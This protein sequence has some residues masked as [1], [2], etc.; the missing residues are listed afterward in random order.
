MNSEQK[1][2]DNQ[3]KWVI[4]GIATVAVLA[5][6]AGSF[7]LI[8]GEQH[9]YQV[10]QESFVQNLEKQNYTELGKLLSQKSIK[11]SGYKTMEIIEKYEA[12]FNGLG[13]NDIKATNIQ[14]KKADSKSTYNLTY[15]LSMVTPLGKLTK[16]QYQ[17]ELVK[18]GKTVKINWKP[19]LIFPN[20]TGQDKVRMTS[21]LPKRGA[22]KDRNGI[23]LA[24]NKEV[25]QLGI[26][27]ERLGTGTEKQENL[28]KI[29]E[30][31]GVPEASINEKLAEPWVKEDLFVP[32]KT[33]IDEE[34]DYSDLTG[35][36]E[37][38]KLVRY[39][40][41][42]EAGAHL[43][44][45]TG[46]VTAEDI[47]KDSSLSAN[48]LIGKSG[49]ELTYDKE[50]RGQEGGKLSI[51]SEDDQEKQVI[52]EQKYQDGQDL[53]TTIDT[54][55]QE[56]AYNQIKAVQGATVVMNPL[57]GDLLA[58]VSAPSFNPNK[59]A[60]GI[61]EKDYQEYADNKQQPFM[62][63]Y[64]V[65]FAPGST[66]KTIT[67]AIGIDNG[68]TT[69]D[70][71]KKIEGLKWQK[72][73]SWGGY[74]V[75]RVSDVPTVNMESALIYS[76][77]IYFAQEA[78][79]MGE[80]NY[81]KGLEKFIFGQKLAIPIPMTPAQISNEEAFGS[82]ILL[83]DTAYGQ[84][85][86]LINPIQQAS[87][88]SVFAAQGDLTMPR[89]LVSE[90]A[91]KKPQVITKEAANLVKNAMIKVVSDPNGTAHLLN[92]SERPLAAKT[93]T[94]EIKVKQDTKGQENSFLLAFD[95]TTNTN[96]VVSLVEDA[97]AGQSAT[98]LNQELIDY[99]ATK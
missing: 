29:S 7:Y 58:L 41:L 13:I 55:V 91:E 31:I 30:K 52:I 61:S 46:G 38:N 71:T 53:M 66:F 97:Q 85:E 81:R 65:G 92:N 1:Q 78:L 40:P 10:V 57:E 35:V 62:A 37:G 27:P 47:E 4:I 80:N 34:L 68:V 79:E 18:E 23:D 77:N 67:A 3:K 60:N 83:A 36:T 48:S 21:Q 59:M 50:L 20:M 54:G 82:E 49:L 39:Y 17:T 25:I 73:D 2:T 72:D 26:V 5:V 75:T 70:K 15:E 32:I 89:L 84:G 19:D 33:L 24:T 96:L 28:K 98:T 87:M 76:D 44:G 51:V 14:L 63:R 88:Y 99:L 11:K 69:L 94:A 74:W 43:I 9:K 95:G 42:K 93:G 45:Y 16:Q 64:A 86:L 90:Q 6:G 56:L 12:V 8:K 22:I